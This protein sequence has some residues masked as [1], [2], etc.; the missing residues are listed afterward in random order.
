MTWLRM[1]ILG[2]ALAASGGVDTAQD[3]FP[4]KP[5]HIYVPFPPGGAVDIVGRALGDELSRRWGQSVIIEN[6]PGAGGAIATQALAKAPAIGFSEPNLQ[7]AVVGQARPGRLH[8]DHHRNRARAQPPPLR[9]AALR[10]V[11]RF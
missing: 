9:Q 4:S 10:Y 3:D 11:R 6:R 2:F 7:L 5:V 1:M 8:V